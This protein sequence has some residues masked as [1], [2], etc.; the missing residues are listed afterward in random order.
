MA[1]VPTFFVWIGPSEAPV[2]TMFRNE[3]RAPVCAIP[4][5]AGDVFDQAMCRKA[6]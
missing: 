4:E 5:A 6:V 1:V 2:E 3:W